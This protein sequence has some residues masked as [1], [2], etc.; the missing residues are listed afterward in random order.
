MST[1]KILRKLYRQ[2]KGLMALTILVFAFMLF[3]L[4]YVHIFTVGEIDAGLYTG[5]III[6]S[7]PLTAA[8]PFLSYEYLKKTKNAHLSEW[9]ETTGGG[10]QRL[11]WLQLGTLMRLPAL[12]TL[13]YLV[14]M[15]VSSCVLMRQTEPM[16]L[17]N[18]SG[19]I[20]IFFFICPMVA[21]LLSAAASLW[22]R[23]LTAY[24]FF[25]LFAILNSPIKYTLE[26]RL[27][28]LRFW[29][30]PLSF[31]FCFYPQGSGASPLY[32]E[33]QPLPETQL[34]VITCWLLLAVFLI[35][36]H[37]CIRQPRRRKEN[38]GV[39]AAAVVLLLS[40]TGYNTLPYSNYN[41]ETF[42]AAL[43]IVAD[44]ANDSSL[45]TP[46]AEQIDDFSVTNCMLELKTGRYLRGK[47]ELTVFPENLSV[48]GFTLHHDYTVKTVTDKEGQALSFTRKG[49]FLTV[50]TTDAKQGIV[51]SYSGAN[52]TFYTTRHSL[53]LPGY[54][55]YYPMAGYHPFCDTSTTHNISPCIQTEEIAF[56]VHISGSGKVYSNLPQT[57][58][59]VF[60]GKATGVSFL[61]GL[62]KS[63]NIDGIELIYPYLDN[64]FQ[65]TDQID[66]AVEALITLGLNSEDCKRI[67]IIPNCNIR[68]IQRQNMLDMGD[69]LLAL[70]L[71]DAEN[72]YLK[73]K[74]LPHKIDLYESCYLYRTS[75]NTFESMV[76]FAEDKSNAAYLLKIAIQEKGEAAVLSACQ[77]FLYD[78]EDTRTTQEFF[79]NFMREG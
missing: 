36:L 47:A 48:Y 76:S 62:L 31:F 2:S 8:M 28:Y 22:C 56:T 59:G 46:P 67:M 65:Q 75:P 18:L 14:A 74:I 39:A 10:T 12:I 66:G 27:S 72:D 68:G 29:D 6:V 45:Y 30:V 16:W 71:N 44:Y 24:L 63:R 77:T 52:N 53:F 69:H 78:R 15:L 4:V 21:V 54:F 13:I 38:L 73:S 11:F 50:E 43:Q 5:N 1:G 37:F 3:M 42:A 17:L 55:P 79:A 33:G 19:S 51:I 26:E 34:I 64:A 41:R 60:Q 35:V 23:R 57:E 40:L 9:M 49:D 7:F 70:D 58:S 20:V 61:G 32:Q 25:T